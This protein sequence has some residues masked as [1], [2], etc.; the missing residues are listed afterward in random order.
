[1]LEVLPP[2]TS[3]G[4]GVKVLLEHL[5]IEPPHL[6]ALGGS[7]CDILHYGRRTPGRMMAGFELRTMITC[8]AWRFFAQR[9]LPMA[10]VLFGDTVGKPPCMQRQASTLAPLHCVTTADP[11][12][13]RSC[14]PFHCMHLSR[15]LCIAAPPQETPRMT[16]TC[17]APPAL[18]CAL[19][20]HL[21]RLE[22]QPASW[23]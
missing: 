7:A 10:E 11:T 18:G 6:M 2:G 20:T 9:L 4:K 22:Q 23:P 12:L 14:A 3:K 19:G 1:M 8:P 21:P 5:G 16:L 17:C 15:C 13:H